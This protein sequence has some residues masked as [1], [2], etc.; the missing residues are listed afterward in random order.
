[1]DYATPTTGFALFVS[2]VLKD[3]WMSHKKDK[4]TIAD[5]AVLNKLQAAEIERLK[6]DIKELKEKYEEVISEQRHKDFGRC[7]NG[8]A[9]IR[10]ARKR[11][12]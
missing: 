6:E 5:E 3:F 4:Q 9:P 8:L 1:M 7:C 12:N 2:L 10:N 11:R